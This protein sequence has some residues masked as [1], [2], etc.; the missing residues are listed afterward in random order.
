MAIKFEI[1]RD[2][3]RLM[4]FEPVGATALGPESLPWAGDIA[5]RDG[6]LV[7]NR[8]DEHASGLS[9]LWDCG[10]A[11]AYQL[12][13]TRL[14]HRDKPYNLNVE[15]ARFRLMKIMQKQEDWNLFDF[16]KADRFTARFDEAQDVFAEAMGKA[17][18]PAEASKIAD[19]AL[20]IGLELSE[21]L[22]AFHSDLLIG[23]RRVTNGFV[24]HI[25]GC[26]VDP[27]VQNEKYKEALAANFD[28]CVL[29]MG[30]KQ[31]QPQENVFATE[32][33]DDWVEFLSR[34]RVPTIAGPLIRLDEIS[35]P[36]WMVIWEHDFDM[37][38][39]MAYDFVQK[40]V[41]RYRRAV[42]AWNV[43]GGVQTNAAFS[44]TFEQVIELTRLLVSQVKT[45][46]PNAPTMITITHPFGEYHAR[47]KPSVPPLF[48]A[49][50]V[51]Q[52]G[53]SFEAF[54]LEVEMG[55]PRPGH[56]TR[57]LFQLS[58]LLDKFSTLGRP[59]FL[60]AVGAPGRATSDPGDTSGGQLDPSAAGRWRKPWDPHLQAD[61]MEAVYNL[62]LSKPFVESIAW[63]DLADI[64]PSLP[65]GG[66]LD[67][68]LRPKPAFQRLQSMREKLKQ[69]QKK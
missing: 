17:D 37:L 10:A 27:S 29:P 68:M 67:D 54:A 50:M 51:A 8:K 41:Q 45:L 20:A 34:R 9:L 31:L 32:R 11:G 30:W 18:E 59:V 21:Q 35:V 13:T 19:R 56:F 66:L 1:Y 2:G 46:I 24:K 14:P 26:R 4:A 52:A 65:A 57:D 64:H 3:A 55:V 47:A 16:P 6:L 23:R 60:T 49:E 53:I 58:S 33:L 40:V 42:A 61:W 38:R 62:A 44:L 22:A 7:V 39:E 28:Y 69:F 43:V 5:F 12:E 48:Y 36:D 25:F 15:L 63:A